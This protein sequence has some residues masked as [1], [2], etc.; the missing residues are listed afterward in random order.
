MPRHGHPGGPLHSDSGSAVLRTPVS[1]CRLE[2]TDPFPTDVYLLDTDPQ[3]RKRKQTL[4]LLEPQVYPKFRERPCCQSNGE[5]K[6]GN[7]IH[8]PHFTDEDLGGPERD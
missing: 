5:W 2:P 3:R 4:L 8:L 1:A 7:Q 6:R